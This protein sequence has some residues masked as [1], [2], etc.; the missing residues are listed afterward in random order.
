MLPNDC[1]SRQTHSDYI[2]VPSIHIYIHIS[3]MITNHEH[4]MHTQF[5]LYRNKFKP[6][7]AIHQIKTHKCPKMSLNRNT[8]N[9]FEIH[10]IHTF[11]HTHN[12]HI[13][14]QTPPYSKFTQT[15][16]ACQWH[17]TQEKLSHVFD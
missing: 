4:C 8:F 5:N 7:S 10:L 16:N 12:P 9:K 3:P 1:S 15:R 11:M 14:M 13:Y 6:N 2:Y 17:Y